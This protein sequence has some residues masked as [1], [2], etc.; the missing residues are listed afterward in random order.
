VYLVLPGLTAPPLGPAALM[1]ASGVAWGVYSLRGRGTT[2]PV[3]ASAGN[4]LH[5]VPMALG[6]AALALVVPGGGLRP[7]VPGV[8]YAVVSGAVTSGLGYVVWYAVLPALQATSAATVQ[9]S[10]P[11]LAALGGVVLLG[12]AVTLRLAAAAVA[13]LGG[14]ALV[15]RAR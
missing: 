11:L 13:I 14:I 5:A 15:L 9:L 7:G 6:L 2:D 1:A 8:A 3:A 12:E 4:F 10:V